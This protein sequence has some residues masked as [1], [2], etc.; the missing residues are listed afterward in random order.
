MALFSASANNG[1]SDTRFDV[2]RPHTF[3]GQICNGTEVV[4]SISGANPGCGL[5]G[6]GRPTPLADST[7]TKQLCFRAAC[8]KSGRTKKSKN[9]GAGPL[10]PPLDDVVEVPGEEDRFSFAF[11][12]RRR[13]ITRNRRFSCPN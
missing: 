1:S 8:T 10:N 4:F 11:L 5:P 9:Q 13:S 2:A 3:F 7:S 6:E 12:C